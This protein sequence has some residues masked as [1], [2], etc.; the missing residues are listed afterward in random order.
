[1]KY[2]ERTKEWPSEL[3]D[4]EA[5]PGETRNAIDDPRQ[6]KQLAGLRDDLRAF[7]S[8]QGAPRL[9]EWRSTTRQRIPTY[10]RVSDGL[11]SP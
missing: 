1:M 2:I 7:F 9:E 6:K 3:F 8:R 4:L 11:R 5:D 10:R